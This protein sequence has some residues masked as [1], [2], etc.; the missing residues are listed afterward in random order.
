MVM[1]R[2]EMVLLNYR[3]SPDRVC[4][5]V[6]G[7]NEASGGGGVVASSQGG[8][9]ARWRREASGLYES[10]RI[11]DGMAAWLTR[12]ARSLTPLRPRGSE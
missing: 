1:R 8:R 10:R 12:V 7:R 5:S 3:R 6:Q 4:E 11:L 9:G 2:Q